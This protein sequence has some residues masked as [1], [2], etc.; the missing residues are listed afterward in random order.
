VRGEKRANLCENRILGSA[1]AATA[2]LR[3]VVDCALQR[4]ASPARARKLYF[5]GKKET[6][7][8]VL[9]ISALLESITVVWP[10]VW[11]QRSARHRGRVVRMGAWHRAERRAGT[12]G[13]GCVHTANSLGGRRRL[14]PGPRGCQ[15]AGREGSFGGIGDRRT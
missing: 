13:I 4:P 12:K 5:F 15:D 9:V 11:P 6:L 7:I 8:H 1:Q 2:A 14:G 10:L 3:L